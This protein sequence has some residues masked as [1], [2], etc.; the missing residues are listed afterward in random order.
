MSG[1]QP[2]DRGSSPLGGNW[3]PADRSC[4]RVFCLDGAAYP[5]LQAGGEHLAELESSQV[6]CFNAEPTIL[7]RGT[8]HDSPGLHRQMAAREFLGTQCRPAALSRPLRI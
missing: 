6:G 1:S 7:S 8:N 5:A 2:E 3:K 4:Q